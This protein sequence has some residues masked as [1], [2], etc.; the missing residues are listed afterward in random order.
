[1]FNEIPGPV[2]IAVSVPCAFV[3][4]INLK[5]FTFKRRLE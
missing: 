3:K 2:T 5:K 4:I 1:M